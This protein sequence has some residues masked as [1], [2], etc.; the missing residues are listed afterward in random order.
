M[1]ENGTDG[2]EVRVACLTCDTQ[3]RH[4]VIKSV[5]DQDDNPWGISWSQHEI[6]T[7]LGC[8]TVSFR[9]TWGTDDI[10]GEDDDGYIYDS[11]EE[12]FPSRVAGRKK[13]RSF[14]SLPSEVQGIYQET[15]QAVSGNQPILGGIGIRAI[16]ETVCREKNAAGNNLESKINALVDIGVLTKEG[17][18]ILHQTRIYGN[19]AAH[20]VN[21]ISQQNLGVL[22][23]IAENLL[24]NVYILPKKAAAL[25][26]K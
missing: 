21:P 3:T 18:E 16:V 25:K 9:K 1:K 7:C 23:D 17:A 13:I 2:K 14:Y 8:E 10:V 22:M 11:S 26:K 12:V 19:D 20:E 15:H 4:K 5:S 6:I 24:E